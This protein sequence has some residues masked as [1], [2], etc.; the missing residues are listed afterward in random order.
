MLGPDV[1]VTEPERFTL[2]RSSTRRARGVKGRSEATAPFGGRGT[3]LRSRLGASD[4]SGCPARRAHNGDGGGI[5]QHAEKQVLRADVVVTHLERFLSGTR[6]AGTGRVPY[7]ARGGARP[8]PEPQPRG[9][10][11]AAARP[12]WSRRVRHRSRPGPAHVTR[13]IYEVPEQQV[14]LAGD[15]TRHLGGGHDAGERVLVGAAVVPVWMSSV[16]DGAG[17]NR[18]TLS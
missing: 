10:R 12:A 5:Y 2:V 11:T 14:G 17:A 6:H 15:L 9:P 18:S 7:T 3:R 1:V 13:R 8:R 16:S 4:Q